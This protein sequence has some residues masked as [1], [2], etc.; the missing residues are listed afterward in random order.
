M[1]WLGSHFTYQ[2][3]LPTLMQP[4]DPRV[5]WERRV[6]QVIGWLTNATTPANLVL[7]YFEE[8]DHEGHLHGPNSDQVNHILSNINSIIKYYLQRLSEHGIRDLVNTLVFSDHGM[9]KIDRTSFPDLN[10][11]IDPITYSLCDVSPGLQIQPK[12]GM[13]NPSCLYACLSS[14]TSYTI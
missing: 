7:M 1:M 11:Y 9:E 8:P 14:T 2:K 6:D 13:E 5:R 10:D 12:T 4:F 3:K